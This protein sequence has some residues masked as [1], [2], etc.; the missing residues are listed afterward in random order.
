MPSP[1]MS[2][3][4]LK[5][6]VISTGLL[7]CDRLFSAEAC[8]RNGGALGLDASFPYVNERACQYKV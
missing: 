7:F 4:S 8:R 5:S 2:S 3:P 1:I 6:A